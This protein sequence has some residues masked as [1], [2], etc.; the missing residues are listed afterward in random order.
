MILFYIVGTIFATLGLFMFLDAYFFRKNA[1]TVQ[2][3]VAGYEKKKS[4]NG[5]HYYPVV[6]Y[7]DEGDRYQFKSDIGSSAMSFSIDEDVEVLILENR[8][9]SARLKRMARPVLAL[10]F[11]FMGLVPIGISVFEIERADHQIYALQG[12]VLLLAAG[13]FALLAFSKTYRE[14]KEREFS[15]SKNEQGL[16]GYET[17]QSI[18]TDAKV[19][20]KRTV[21]KNAYAFGAVIGT[22]MVAGS[23]YWSSQLHAYMESAI[24]TH[25]TIVSQKSSYSD[26]STTYAPV[27][28]FRPYKS[29]TIMFTSNI[30]SSNPSWRVGDDVFVLYDPNNVDDAMMD[31]GWF[32][33]FFQLLLGL[34]GAFMLALSGWQLWKKSQA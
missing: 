1:R 30:G 8:H 9:S 10:A 27:I 3:S 32:N 14:R 34:T 13:V 25:G 6:R 4:K 23:L 31:R 21:S 29:E 2:G 18:I 20:Q 12:A 26:G 19:I 11:L 17:T 5:Y 7:S 28:E 22:V 16:I 33:Y 15:Y 24:R